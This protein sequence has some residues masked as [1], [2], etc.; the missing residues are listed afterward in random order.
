MKI[1]QFH[2]KIIRISKLP[3][4]WKTVNKYD[5]WIFNLTIIALKHNVQFCEMH[6]QMA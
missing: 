4:G 5:M 3:V 2:A 1:S 6:W